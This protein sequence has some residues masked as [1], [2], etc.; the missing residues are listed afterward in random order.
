MHTDSSDAFLSP[1]YCLPADTVSSCVP[2]RW[3]SAGRPLASRSC[4]S[5]LAWQ[6][7]WFVSADP[8]RPPATPVCRNSEETSLQRL[9]EGAGKPLFYPRITFWPLTLVIF[10]DLKKTSKFNFLVRCIHL[11]VIAIGPLNEYSITE[12]S[13]VWL[14]GNM[15]PICLIYGN[16]SWL[17]GQVCWA[18]RLFSRSKMSNFILKKPKLLRRVSAHFASKWTLNEVAPKRPAI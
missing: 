13:L 3:T 8:G 9:E 16:L 17:S 6:W 4:H 5:D 7:Q 10:W 15:S 1:L 18:R 14:T 2:C 11:K 12:S